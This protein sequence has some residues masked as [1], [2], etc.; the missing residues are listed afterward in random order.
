MKLFALTDIERKQVRR[1]IIWHLA[2]LLC[3]AFFFS[4]IYYWGFFKA[5]PLLKESPL[6]LLFAPLAT[7][8]F[9]VISPWRTNWKK[10]LISMYHRLEGEAAFCLMGALVL[11]LGFY[12]YSVFLWGLGALIPSILYM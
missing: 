1:L 4:I 12:L 7:I 6:F 8:L 11:V 9:I 3:I 5:H 2:Y 10:A